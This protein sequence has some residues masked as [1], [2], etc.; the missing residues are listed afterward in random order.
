MKTK[1]TLKQLIAKELTNADLAKVTGGLN[2]QPLP[3]GYWPP[4]PI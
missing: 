4:E 3:P 1:T 2:P